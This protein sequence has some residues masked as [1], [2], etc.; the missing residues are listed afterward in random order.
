MQP[1]AVVEDFD[2]FG[3]G[4]ARPCPGGEGLPVVHLVLQGSEEWLGGG[5]V[6]AHAGPAQASANAMPS[7]ECVKLGGRILGG[8]NGSSQ[9]LDQEVW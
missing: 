2:V 3:D 5:V 9:H 4:E 7:S 6:P 8:F 1:L